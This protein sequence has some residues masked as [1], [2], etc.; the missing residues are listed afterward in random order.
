MSYLDRRCLQMGKT[1]KF[2]FTQKLNKIHLHN[3]LDR[4]FN[5]KFQVIQKKILNNKIE[6]NFIKCH[7]IIS[8]FTNFY[9]RKNSILQIYFGSISTL[10]FLIGHLSSLDNT[11]DINLNKIFSLTGQVSKNI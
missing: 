8:C 9:T 6:F 4:R 3:F 5:I 10:F 7:S 1:F 11:L 2:F